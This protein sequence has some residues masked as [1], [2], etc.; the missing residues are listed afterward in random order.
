MN[1][2]RIHRVS[3]LTGL[4]KDVIRVW[5]RRYGLVQPT[6]G[7]NRYRNYTDDDVALLRYVRNEMEKG[8][9]IG[10]LAS[11]GREELLIRMRATRAHTISEDKSYGRLLN[12][13]LAALQPLK[14]TTFERKLNGSVA[15][16]PFEEALL[17]IL[18]PL[19]Q[20]VGQLWHD[21]R[22]G[23]ATEHYV[24]KQVQQKIFAAMNQLPVHQQGPKVVVACLSGQMHEIGAQTIAY[25]CGVRG[26]RV[27]YLGPNLP[28]DA[29]V[30]LCVEVRPDLTILSFPMML[31]DREA[32]EFTHGPLR[33]I[34]RNSS[35]LAGGPGALAMRKTLENVG[36]EV[37]ENFEDIERRLL[38]IFVDRLAIS[39]SSVEFADD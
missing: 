32:Q 11:V 38:K 37:L 3:K 21:G 5:E 13:L 10:Q 2:H 31:H 35:I 30:A 39:P 33:K 27:Y 20:Q 26:C 7:A 18:L 28:V 15:I 8:H 1:M 6:R 34:R 17:K 14:R 12:E 23:I 9:S 16:I 25:R 24:T 29:L 22:L 36:V 4:S 19:Q